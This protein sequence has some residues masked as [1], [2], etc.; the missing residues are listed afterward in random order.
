MS[1]CIAAVILVLI[2]DMLYRPGA[3]GIALMAGQIGIGAGAALGHASLVA[4]TLSTANLDVFIPAGL[5]I[6]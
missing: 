1:I 3:G 2:A 5:E 6:W 4:K